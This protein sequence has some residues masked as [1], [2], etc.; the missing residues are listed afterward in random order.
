MFAV[1]TRNILRFFSPEFLSI[2]EYNS[3]KKTACYRPLITG[4]FVRVFTEKTMGHQYRDNG[5]R[6]M[7]SNYNQMR[8]YVECSPNQ[9]KNLYLIEISIE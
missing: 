2:R 4:H 5:A 1:L 3:D 7:Y 8:A 6:N 9:S